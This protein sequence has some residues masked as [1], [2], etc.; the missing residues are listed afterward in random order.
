M[1]TLAEFTKTTL[2]GGLL[3]ILP[4]YLSVLL[5]A[6]AVTGLLALMRPVTAQIPASVQF[7]Q[8]LAILLIAAAC[9]IAGL[10][11][12]TGPGL[13][14]KN[15]FE[16]AILE[17]LPGYTLLRGLAGR[18]TGRA[19]EPAFAPALVEIEEALVPALIVEELEDG[20]Y[21]VLVPSVPTPMA[22]ALYILPRERVHPVD[23]PFTKA[24]AVFT[25]WGT[26]AGEF[27]RAMQA[28][29]ISSIS[30]PVA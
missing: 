13:R 8:V 3:I 23:V 26:G 24:L 11:V 29:G 5:L 27:V 25:K 16:R 30:K 2:I 19:D 14:A 7:R 21:T 12:R 6:K 28:G 18:V 10:I 22:G 20:S 17:K 15:A 4:I 1:K 9:F